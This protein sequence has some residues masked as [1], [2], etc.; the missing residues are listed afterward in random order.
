MIV[1]VSNQ[2]QKEVPAFTSSCKDA[3]H[4]DELLTTNA[5]EPITHKPKGTPKLATHPPANAKEGT[6]LSS[7]T[8]NNRTNDCNPPSSDSNLQNAAPI[9]VEPIPDGGDLPTG[10]TLLSM[11][12]S[13]NDTDSDEELIATDMAGEAIIASSSIEKGEVKAPR[14][15]RDR[16]TSQLSPS[17]ITT[18][19]NAGQS[20]EEENTRRGVA[21]DTI[22]DVY[23]MYE[24]DGPI[25]YRQTDPEAEIAQP[26]IT[27]KQVRTTS[28]PAIKADITK[29]DALP[30]KNAAPL[31]QLPGVK[32]SKAS[33]VNQ[34]I[35]FENKICRQIDT[36]IYIRNFRTYSLLSMKL[37]KQKM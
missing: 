15:G 24:E 17:P 3:D 35:R 9:V 19:S 20:K 11:F 27:K 12:D 23:G 32:Q 29:E 8:D 33:K 22:D 1:Q 6:P 10:N 36:S 21:Q 13:G 25:E 28:T 16:T 5:D 18:P 34:V 26:L 2:S 31:A 4:G 7:A 37:L 30:A 14:T